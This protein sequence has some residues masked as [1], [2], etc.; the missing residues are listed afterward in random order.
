MIGI[1]TVIIVQFNLD[2]CRLVGS[3]GLFTDDKN[4]LTIQ[5]RNITAFGTPHII[6][7]LH[8]HPC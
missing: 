4:K 8:L 5:W 2:L 1:V 6:E 3:S 7:P